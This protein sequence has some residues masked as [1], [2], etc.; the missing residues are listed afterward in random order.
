MHR[1]SRMVRC[2]SSFEMHTYGIFLAAAFRCSPWSLGQK[3]FD[4]MVQLFIHVCKLR[5]DPLDT[6]FETL[7]CDSVVQVSASHRM[8]VYR[9]SFLV[10][11]ATARPDLSRALI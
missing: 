6:L 9:L 1:G 7:D 8:L 4:A 3:S 5:D 2:L 10:W 11:A